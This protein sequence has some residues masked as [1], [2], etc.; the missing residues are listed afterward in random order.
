MRVAPTDDEN[1]A[2]VLADEW[3]ARVASGLKDAL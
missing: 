2:H 3:Q 1:Y